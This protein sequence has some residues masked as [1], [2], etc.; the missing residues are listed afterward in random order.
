MEGR[1]I[2]VA[3]EGCMEAYKD[4]KRN[5]KWCVH[6]SK[7]EVNKLFGRK[8]NEVAVGSRKLFWK[9]VVGVN[10]REVESCGR[11]KNRNEGLSVGE[12]VV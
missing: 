11:R 1:G 6:E 4:E 7:E 9:E 10:G 2:D 5:V 3:K 8:I 12:G